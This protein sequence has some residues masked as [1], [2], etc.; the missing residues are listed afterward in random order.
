M[1]YF[2]DDIIEAM[3]RNNEMVPISEKY[4][5]I[6][7]CD[8]DFYHLSDGYGMYSKHFFLY[9]RPFKNHIKAILHYIG[10]KS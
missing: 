8:D 6:E 10:F 2:K 9:R 5:I 3:S 7:K 1:R 4:R